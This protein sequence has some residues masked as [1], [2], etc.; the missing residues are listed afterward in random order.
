MKSAG[1]LILYGKS[2]AIGR[3]SVVAGQQAA[4]HTPGMSRHRH[5]RDPFRCHVVMPD[6]SVEVLFG[7]TATP[8]S[9]LEIVRATFHGH[10]VRPVKIQVY[11]GGKTRPVGKPLVEWNAR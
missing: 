3:C 2:N 11:R 9:A 7:S 5:Q 4:N 6:G 10:A 8:E 1:L